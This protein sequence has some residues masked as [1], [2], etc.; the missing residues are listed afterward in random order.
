MTVL[1]D[2][3][4]NMKAVL[5]VGGLG[6]RLRP[7]VS[8]TPKVL[9]SLDGRPFLELLVR[10]LAS[11]GIRHLVMC[12]GYLA[13]QIKD[14]F[15]D[16]GPFGVAIEYSQEDV[17][18]G[19]AGALALSKRFLAHQS[20]FLVLNG[21]SFFDVDF[22][23][24][25]TF[26]AN[27]G[28]I[29]SIAAVAVENASRYGTLRLGEN[30]RVVGFQEKN[31]REEPG[32]VNAGV[33]VFR[34]DVLENIPNGPASLERDIFPQV[35]SE[36]VFALT[37]NGLFIDIGTPEDYALARSIRDRLVSAAVKS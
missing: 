12:T 20:D 29:A 6:T 2:K 8:G 15:G 10:Q 23:E 13:E 32:T 9:A 14:Q 35:L 36:G 26:H 22:Q 17:P 33:Y 3:S 7:S 34:H 25:I 27:H 30:G 18:L 28:G 19:T 1:T 37:K 16:G 24:L 21:D 11:Q 4:K 31:G 5:L